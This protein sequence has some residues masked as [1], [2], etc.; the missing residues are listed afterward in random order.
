M[1]IESGLIRQGQREFK[2][3]EVQLIQQV[4][5]RFPKLSRHV[6]AQTLCEHLNWYSPS[7]ALK[8]KNCH[9]LLEQLADQALLVL[10]KKAN[11]K[12]LTPDSRPELSP[13]TAEPSPII[14]SLKLTSVK[15]VT[16]SE[17]AEV[18]LWN[19]YVERYHPLGHRRPFG[20][21]LRYFI[22]ADSERVGCLMISGAAK[23]LHHRDHWIGWS[24]TYRQ[25]NLPWVI[26]NNRYLLFPW[27]QI[28]HLASHVLG[29]L[30]RRVAQD[31]EDRW[32]YRPVL[33]ETFVDP[34]Y[35]KGTCYQ[36]AGWEVLGMTRGEGSVRP[37][38][39]YQ[40]SPKTILAKPLN[41]HFRALLCAEE[42]QGRIIE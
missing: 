11:T 39:S 32:G 13:R 28:P 27:V 37:G 36:A 20:N 23:A 33:L 40:T 22:Y 21:W 12:R 25:R 5:S 29:Q 16:V 4:V 41:K 17:K 26:N 35:F 7:G 31:W 19:E 38:K 42:L 3:E 14:S 8:T 15:L 18:D 34:L 24:A 30:V 6:L 2:A 9:L 1:V 10:P